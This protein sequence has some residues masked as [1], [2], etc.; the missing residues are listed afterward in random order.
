[1]PGTW[2]D[3][4]QAQVLTKHP[5]HMCDAAPGPQAP[6]SVPEL[7]TLS[8]SLMRA[9]FCGDHVPAATAG[10]PAAPSHGGPFLWNSPCSLEEPS[11]LTSLFPNSHLHHPP[12]APSSSTL[13]PRLRSSL[14]CAGGG[15][16]HGKGSR[17]PGIKPSW[18]SIPVHR[19]LAAD[20]G[21][22]IRSTIRFLIPKMRKTRQATQNARHCGCLGGGRI[23]TR[24]EDT[25][26][27]ALSFFARLA[28][29]KSS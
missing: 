13:L 1:M 4:T 5:D 21:L 15:G 16:C 28:P 3:D 24:V 27:T 18:V 23:L 6:S 19:L 9:S 12:V 14:A 22:V 20:G 25:Q 17:G 7:F 26:G 8:P 29:N 11:S 2:L 10:M